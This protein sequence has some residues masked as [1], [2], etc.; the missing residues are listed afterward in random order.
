MDGLVTRTIY[1]GGRELEC[2]AW[3]RELVG[4]AGPFDLL[5][6]QPA[7]DGGTELIGERVARGGI[8]EAGKAG[9]DIEVAE[10]PTGAQIRS[11][12]DSRDDQKAQ[13]LL[14]YPFPGWIFPA[15]RSAA[16]SLADPPSPVLA[17]PDLMAVAPAARNCRGRPLQEEGTCAGLRMPLQ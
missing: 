12:A 9:I 3:S 13:N 4:A 11:S 16:T 5:G 8:L 2:A 6:R 14:H 10:P 1:L 15:V 17:E 7:V